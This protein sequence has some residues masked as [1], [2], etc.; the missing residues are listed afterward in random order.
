MPPF[1]ENGINVVKSHAACINKQQTN[2]KLTIARE[3]PKTIKCSREQHAVQTYTW[4]SIL[5]ITLSIFILNN[6][7]A[8]R[9][10]F[11]P[12]NLLCHHTFVC[13]QQHS[14]K[15][16]HLF[17]CKHSLT[18]IITMLRSCWLQCTVSNVNNAP[19][20]VSC[21]TVSLPVSDS[22]RKG[23]SATSL[24]SPAVAQER[25]RTSAHFSIRLVELGLGSVAKMVCF[26]NVWQP[27]TVG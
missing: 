11:H 15:M 14:R 17:R 18:E 5:S 24:G 3:R 4:W 13:Q 9:R 16:T 26:P 22:W 20:S 27:L 7:T 19:C 21:G 2:N 10:L 25:M 8:V 12:I 1:P 6:C 23:L